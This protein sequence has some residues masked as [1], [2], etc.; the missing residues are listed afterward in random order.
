[1]I[2]T[3]LGILAVWTL[4]AMPPAA[5]VARSITYC[6]RRDRAESPQP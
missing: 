6:M 2:A 1:M 5:A 4:L 3:L